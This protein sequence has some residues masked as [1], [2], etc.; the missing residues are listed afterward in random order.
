DVAYTVRLCGVSRPATGHMTAWF[1]FVVI[2]EQAGTADRSLRHA[3]AAERPEPADRARDDPRLGPRLA[4]RDLPPGGHLEADGLA[5]DPV[6]PRRGTRSRGARRSRRADLRRRV[7]R[8]C[9]RGGP[10][11][12]LRPR[13]ALP[14]RSG[15]RPTW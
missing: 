15:L 12:R 4:G 8:A 3:P 11:P 14:A 7:L 6:A 5:R 9:A 10:G 2:D 13:R 1:A